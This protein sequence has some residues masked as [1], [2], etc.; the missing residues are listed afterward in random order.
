MV[1]SFAHKHSQLASVCVGQKPRVAR[2]HPQCYFFKPP[3]ISADVSN[4]LYWGETYK[5]RTL[6]KSV[7]FCELIINYLSF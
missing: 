1:R 7:S 4:M 2:S 6:S 5:E 3:T